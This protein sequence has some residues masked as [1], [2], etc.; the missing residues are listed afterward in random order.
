VNKHHR[1]LAAHARLAS[2]QR[3][4]AALAGGGFELD[5]ASTWDRLLARTALERPDVVLVSD[6]LPGLSFYEGLRRLRE[7]TT[8]PVIVVT[9]E[10][11]LKARIVALECGADDCIA[12]PVNPD[13]LTARVRAVLRRSPHPGERA[14]LL[15]AGHAVIDLDQ[16]LVRVHG[17]I[18]VLTRT[19]WDVLE[20]LAEHPGKVMTASDVLERTWGESFRTDRAYLRCWVSRLRTKLDAACPDLPCRNRGSLIRTY[21]GVGYMLAAEYEDRCGAVIVSTGTTPS[22]TSTADVRMRATV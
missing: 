3:I 18:V 5:R 1:A 9:R 15:R 22:S 21:Y 6:R 11:T 8:V 17:R 12:E 10:E 20:V 7:A 14:P 2:R 19:E 4:E 13:E 16:R